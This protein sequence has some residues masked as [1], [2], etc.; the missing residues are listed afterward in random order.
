MVLL[1]SSLLALLCLMGVLG[2]TDSASKPSEETPSDLSPTRTPTRVATPTV[3]VDAQLPLRTIAVDGVMEVGSVLRA[4][5]S[6]DL[7]GTI[8]SWGWHRCNEVPFCLTIKGA[9]EPEYQLTEDDAWHVLRVI[10]VASR[11][12]GPPG[13]VD[14]VVGPIVNGS[15][16]PF[17]ESVTG[18]SGGGATITVGAGLTK[19]F[20]SSQCPVSVYAG[21]STP[22]T[23]GPEITATASAETIAGT[24]E[25]DLDSEGGELTVVG[26]G[27][28]QT[29]FLVQGTR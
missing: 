28:C 3:T 18:S 15:P 8:V 21:V 2:C 20:V 14:T 11:P 26:Y 23:D 24:H 13:A 9:D 22:G 6:P 5:I 16:K 25:L 17:R 29:S 27:E 7:E 1:R 10:A 19:V 12:D 4:R